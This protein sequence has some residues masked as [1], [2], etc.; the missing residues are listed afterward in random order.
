[1]TARLEGVPGDVPGDSQPDVSLT[2]QPHEVAREHDRRDLL[3]LAITASTVDLPVPCR[4][5][6]P[7]VAARWTSERDAD[8][9][10][11]ARLCAG[12][13]IFQVCGWFATKWPREDGVYG[14][15]TFRDRVPHR[16]A[17]REA[18][19]RPAWPSAWQADQPDQTRGSKR[20]R[21]LRR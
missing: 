12:C 20:G 2:R 13:S 21:G 18:H 19:T 15:L 4:D 9:R 17:P 8:Q 7:A 11:A 1:M 5:A 6:D 3:E 14:G 10:V 16:D